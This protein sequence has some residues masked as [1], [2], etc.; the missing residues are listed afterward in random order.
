MKELMKMNNITVTFKEDLLFKAEHIGIQQGECLA[1][2]GRNGA[3][4]STLMRLMTEDLLPSTGHIQWFDTQIKPLLVAQEAATFVEDKMVSTKEAQLLS[5]WQ[6]PNLPYEKL[7]G[8]EKLKRRLAF[9]FAQPHGL[10]LLD[11]PT[12]HLDK[13]STAFLIEQIKSYTGTVVLVSHDRYFIDAVATKIWSIES[14]QIIEQMGNYSHYQS[15]RENREKEQARAFDKQ[16]KEIKRVSNQMNTLQSWSSE[17]HAQ[18]TKQEGF[19]EYYRGKA[20]RMDTQVKSKQKRLQKEIDKA[21]LAP[22]TQEVFDLPL[23]KSPEKLFTPDNRSE[24]A[25]IRHLFKQLGFQAQQWFNPISEMSMGERVKC[26]LM[27]Y[28]IEGTNVL[29]LDEP[30]NHLDLPSREQL[31]VTLA[32]FTGTLIVVSHDRYFIEKVTDR[33]LLLKDKKIGQPLEK[34]VTGEDNDTKRLLLENERQHILGQLSLLT[35]KDSSYDDLDKAFK[36]LSQ[37]IRNLS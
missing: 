13:D 33:V 23:D 31:E 3:G 19:K 7:S 37:Q 1:I 8:G 32:A 18:S 2:I 22:I 34:Q 10:L 17:A 5:Q 30:T 28:I 26:K 29:V 11:E 15:V 21:D 27:R 25:G 12:N 16:K 9:G 24:I 20:K 4:K 35:P 6:V 14:Q 36:E